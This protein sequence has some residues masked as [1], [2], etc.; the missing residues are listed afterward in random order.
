MYVSMSIAEMGHPYLPAGDSPFLPLF[1]DWSLITGRGGLQNGKIA[2]SKLCAHASQDRAK[3][4]MP[5]FKGWKLFA[6]PPSLQ[7]GENCH[8][9]FSSPPSAWLK[10]F[11][12]FPI[13]IGVK[14]YLPALSFFLAPPPSP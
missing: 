8:K 14:L 5:P 12:L 2:G 9:T 7:Y 13:F 10:L 11:P 1:T 3:A 6:T 4:F